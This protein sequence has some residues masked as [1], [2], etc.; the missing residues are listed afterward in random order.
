MSAKDP[1]FFVHPEILQLPAY[2]TGV[3]HDQ[4]TGLGPGVSAL[5]LASNENLYGASPRV[6][7]AIRES[8]DGIHLYP[9]TGTN[10]LRERMAED[11]AVEPGRLIFSTGSENILQALFFATFGAGD[12]I[13]CL[14]PTFL[15]ASIF[16][17][18]ANGVMTAIPYEEDLRF[19]VDKVCA[20]LAADET[21]LLYLSNP[22]NPTGN[23]F[24]EGELEHIFGAASPQTLI[25]MDE[26]YYEYARD[27]VGFGSS[28][29]VLDRLARPYIVLRTF[30]KAYGLANLRVGY[31]LCYHPA[32]ADALTK[33]ST[34]FDVSGLAEVAALAAWDDQEH[35]RRSVRS[36]LEEKQRVSEAMRAAGLSVFPSWTNFLT[37]RF[38]TL[39][40]AL[41][42]ETALRKK[43][44][45][46]K[47]L[48]GCRGEG[49]LR[50]TVGRAADNDRLLHE[51]FEAS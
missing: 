50:V 10:A 24:D 31:A 38:D 35:L 13:V 1:E 27:A 29:P 45:F 37:L 12:R 28:L 44:V 26:A 33:G 9:D 34:I 39:D 42:R 25:V 40:E 6:V 2:K 51:I 32:L 22:N 20:A 41:A 47:G 15:L 49:L 36:T 30:S 19:D 46:V 8:L 48:P 4:L 43:G 21:K 18:A 3:K 11:L 5:R 14:E 17:R 7:D 23:A 16:A